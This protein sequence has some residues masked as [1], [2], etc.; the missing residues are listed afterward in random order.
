VKDEAEAPGQ[1]DDKGADNQGHGHLVTVVFNGMPKEI[2]QGRYSVPELK[3]VLGV[4]PGYEL[5]QIV[6]GEP[7]PLGDDGHVNVKK[8]DAFVSH[9]PRGGAS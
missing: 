5:D 4:E 1:K 7:Q 2:R 8:G 9:V 6:N 3:A